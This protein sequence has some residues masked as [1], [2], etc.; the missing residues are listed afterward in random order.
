MYR[1]LSGRVL[2]TG[3]L[4]IVATC[5]APASQ[6]PWR[7][8]ARYELRMTVDQ[9]GPLTPELESLARPLHDTTTLILHVTAVQG[10]SV[11]G[12]YEG[13]LIRLGLMVGRVGSGPQLFAG[14]VAG[15]SFAITLS[16]DAADA[17]L[18][19][20]GRG[21]GV[22]AAGKWASRSGAITGRAQVRSYA[23]DGGPP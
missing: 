16:S 13:S 12:T 14:R 21:G 17:G 22:P 3:G 4:V 7:P 1:A 6:G 18:T 20:A 11:F 19:V 2:A 23:E 5:R 8:G 10:D 15:A 9:R